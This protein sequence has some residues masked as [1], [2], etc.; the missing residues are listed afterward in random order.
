MKQIMLEVPYRE[1]ISRLFVFRFL[2]VYLA[3][4]PI[5]LLGLWIGILKFLEFWY[6]L[7]M[8]K[9]KE[10]WWMAVKQY[11]A[12]IMQWSAYFQLLVDKRPNFWW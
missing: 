2:W 5:A 7:F 1:K 11:F 10:S 4:W 3:M 9:R 12:W 8:G 6:M